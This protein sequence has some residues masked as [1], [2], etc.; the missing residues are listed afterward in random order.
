MSVCSCAC[1]W[2]TLLTWINVS[3]GSFSK[4]GDSEGE[5]GIGISLG[6][7]GWG[8]LGGVEEAE[9]AF[10]ESKVDC[11]P[12][13]LAFAS[14]V[15]RLAFSLSSRESFLP[16]DEILGAGLALRPR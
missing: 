4:T 11:V 9:I 2:V 14:P 12:C 7:T 6:D 8:M 16:V 1:F 15:A 10:W 13:L 5:S 3:S